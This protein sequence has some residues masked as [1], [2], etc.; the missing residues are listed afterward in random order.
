MKKKYALMPRVAITWRPSSTRAIIWLQSYIVDEKGYK[1]IDH[2]GLFS[3]E[4]SG[5]LFGDW[6]R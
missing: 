2:L 6:F 1:R 5:S 3:Y 4:F